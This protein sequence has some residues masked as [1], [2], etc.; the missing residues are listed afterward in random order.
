MEKLKYL[1][2]TVIKIGLLKNNIYINKMDFT[3]KWNNSY[4]RNENHLF[5]PSDEV[6][7][8][9]LGILE[10]NRVKIL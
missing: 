7:K 9:F 5:Y 3:D 10:K 4:R 8:F 1:K 2:E 6:V